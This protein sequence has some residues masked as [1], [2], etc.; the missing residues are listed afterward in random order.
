M[1]KKKK[2]DN[3]SVKVFPFFFSFFLSEMQDMGIIS[4]ELVLKILFLFL[5]YKSCSVVESL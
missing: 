1:E 2:L 5:F 3:R 4:S